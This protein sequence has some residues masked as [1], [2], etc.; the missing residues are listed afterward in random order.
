MKMWNAWGGV[1]LRMIV[2]Q[3]DEKKDDENDLEMRMTMTDVDGGL[4]T[5][6]TAGA[7]PSLTRTLKGPL[8]SPAERI[9]RRSA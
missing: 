1:S 9:S 4:R 6:L 5:R 2:E 7:S 8:D 3:H